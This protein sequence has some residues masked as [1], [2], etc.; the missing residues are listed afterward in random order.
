M[1][2]V[3]PAPVASFRASR[4]QFWIGIIVGVG[5]MFEKTLYPLLAVRGNLRQPD[6]R[7]YRFDLAKEWSD[8]VECVMPPMLKQTS[9]F[10]RNLP[11]V[12]D[13][14]SFAMGPHDSRSSLMM[15]VG[16]YCCSSVESPLPFIENNCA[17]WSEPFRFF[18]FGNRRDELCSAA[19]FDNLLRWLA[20]VIELPMPRRI[21]VGRVKDRLL[22]KGVDGHV[23][24]G[25]SFRTPRL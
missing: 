24:T 21:L 3:L 5:K 20:L 11:V 16:S 14:V 23:F 9:C 22:K 13:S 12:L 15:E 25:L 1:T 8:I 10:R 2:V 19:G 18:G 6:G 4:M 17:V 7:F